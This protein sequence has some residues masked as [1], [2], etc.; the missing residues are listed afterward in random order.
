MHPELQRIEQQY[1]QLVADLQAGHVSESDAMRIISS[2][3]AIDGEGA[4]WSIDPYSGNFVRAFPGAAPV[5]ADPGRFV[6]AQLPPVQVAVPPHGTPPEMVSDFLH[7]AL[8]PLPPEPVSKRAGSRLRGGLKG[9]AGAAGAAGGALG[10]LLRGRGRTV[11]LVGIVAVVALALIAGS[12]SEESP[13][14]DSV[15]ATVAPI[16]VPDISVPGETTVPPAPV[17]TSA[18]LASDPAIETVAPEPVAPTSDELDLLALLLNAGDAV[19]LAEILPG[20]QAMRDQFALF[21]GYPRLGYTLVLRNPVVTG[22][23]VKVQGTVVKDGDTLS[24]W[25]LLLTGSAPWKVL[26]IEL[27]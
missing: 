13:P 26:A 14:E 4:V 24:R 23:G 9:A 7:P 25:S 6:P 8:R 16:T 10:G 27:D 21:L 2:L 1:L 17:D 20:D 12:P 22:I 11:V 3:T 5:A 18:P 15:P 19:T